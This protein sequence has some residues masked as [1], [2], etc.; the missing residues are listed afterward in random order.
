[1]KA[2]IKRLAAIQELITGCE[3]RAAFYE[4]E[5]NIQIY[6]DG[7]RQ[8]CEK[9]AAL[10]RRATFRLYGAM[11]RTVRL[12]NAELTEPRFTW[13]FI[14]NGKEVPVSTEKAAKKLAAAEPEAIVKVYDEDGFIWDEVA[15]DLWSVN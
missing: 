12:L 9:R 4:R 2:K 1:M 5:A 13:V 10:Y 7:L 6:P 11:K 3:R 15:S 8:H 14:I